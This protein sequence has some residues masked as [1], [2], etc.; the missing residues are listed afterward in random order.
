MKNRVLWFLVSALVAG[1]L[2]MVSCGPKTTTAP[3][4]PPSPAP[5]PSPTPAPSP[6]PAPSPA[7][8]PS[9]EKPKYGGAI[10][11]L[12]ANQNVIEVW[13]SAAQPV[14]MGAATYLVYE[15]LVDPLWE[16]GLAGTGEIDWGSGVQRFE[17]F[18]ANL[19]ESWQI[20]EAG[21]W[22]L[23]IRKGV[24]FALTPGS[25][26][27][28]LVNGRE[29]TTDDVVW[30]IRRF[31]TDPAFPNASVRRSY[32]AFSKAVTVEKTGPQEITLNTKED[33]WIGF[34]WVVYGGNSQHIFAP[35]V[36]Q[37]Y[38]NASDWQNAVGTGPFIATDFVA[39]SAATFA[40]NPNFWM[41][42]MAG[43]G[44][45]DQLPYVDTVKVLI[46]PDNSTRLA[47]MRTGRADFA[48]EVELED[49]NALIKTNPKLKYKKYLSAG[50]TTGGA[51]AI[52][53]RMDKAELP[54]KDKRVR[55]ALMMATD[56]EAM[57]NDLYGGQAEIQVF[58]VPPSYDWL[59]MPMKEL[60]EAVQA[61]Y[62]YNPEKAK[63]LLADAGYPK[64]FKAKIIVQNIS[65]HMDPA[66]VLKAMWAKAGVDLEIQPRETAV[67]NSILSGTQEELILRGLSSSLTTIFSMGGYRGVTSTINDPVVEA[68]YQEVQKNV[69]INM[70]KA[71]ESF[72]KLVPYVMEQAYVL[73]RPTPYSY[74]F[75]QPWV[76]NLYGEY[77]LNLF[78]PHV[79]VD[80]DLKEQMTGRK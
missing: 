72:R 36:I 77:T 70:S 47:A 73:P 41:K 60:P 7:P 40:R 8:A 32:P 29:M 52:F 5:A 64:G 63:Q 49:G 10:N 42:E 44:K 62:K 51:V 59:T 58:P 23:K 56:F 55:Q 34:F 61:L 43:S 39:G 4:P 21:I 12:Q 11:I 25:E 2:L 17:G 20:P 3:A 28:K 14:G 35:E 38:G 66:A 54:F 9:A 65:A 30:N 79:W 57:K 6:K 24:H 31:H 37:K 19:A 75:W 76:K 15:R 18:G 50:S 27:S 71:D 53:M 33:P 69:F 22:I 67:Y 78:L 16:K 68:A 26:A 48:T 45:G 1:M 80:Q 74:T 13:D 46:V